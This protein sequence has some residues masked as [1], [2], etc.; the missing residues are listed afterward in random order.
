MKPHTRAMIAAAAYAFM[1]GQKVAGLHDHASGRDLQ[2]AAEARG[3]QLQGYDGDRGTQFGG[4]LPELYDVGEQAFVSL[5]I[6]GTKATGYD[7]RSSNAYAA[8]VSEG[9]VQLYDYGQGAWFAFD[10]QVA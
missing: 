6:N 7:R 1:S 8:Q 2:I 10:I 9:R 5:E 4:A 3:G